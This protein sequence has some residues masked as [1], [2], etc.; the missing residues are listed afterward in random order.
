MRDLPNFGHMNT[1][2]V[3]FES[4]DKILLVYLVKLYFKDTWSSQ[5]YLH[6]QNCN[7]VHQNDL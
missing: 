6:Q 3:K 7:H 5:F 1:S 2:T 4:C